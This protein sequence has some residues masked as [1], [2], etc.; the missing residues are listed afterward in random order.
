MYFTDCQLSYWPRC[1]VCHRNPCICLS[2]IKVVGFLV[3]SVRP[4]SND[5]NEICLLALSQASSSA[6]RH[7]Q[8]QQQKLVNEP[9]VGSAFAI[10]SLA[11]PEWS[12]ISAVTSRKDGRK[13]KSS[14]EAAQLDNG[15]WK[16]VERTGLTTGLTTVSRCRISCYS[17]RNGFSS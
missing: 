3:H 5:I 10:A 9:I 13:N 17:F 7:Q 4:Q 15:R 11:T 2:V 12:S 8:Q 6:K 1:F 14:S 16:L